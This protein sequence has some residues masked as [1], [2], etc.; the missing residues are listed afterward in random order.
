M[1][2]SEHGSEVSYLLPFDSSAKFSRLFASLDD[3]Q[4]ELAILGYGATITTLEEVFLRFLNIFV[5][6]ENI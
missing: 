5:V 4:E 6:R 1:F 3:K 2:E